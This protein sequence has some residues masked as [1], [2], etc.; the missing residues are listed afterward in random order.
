VR[1]VNILSPEFDAAWDRDGYR[2]RSAG[3]G[4]QLGAEKIGATLYELPEGEKTFP[5]H[6]HHGM[7]EWVLVVAG[8]PVLRGPEGERELRRGDVVCFPP[9]PGGGHQL[10]GPGTVLMLSAQRPLEAIEYPDSGKVAVSPP[11][12]IFRMTDD[13]DYFEGES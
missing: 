8:T 9:G 4:K 6:F 3:I 11:R 12:K 7:E 2:R 13:V 1:K 5:Y 10:R